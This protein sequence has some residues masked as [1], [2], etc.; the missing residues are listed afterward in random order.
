MLARYGPRIT[1]VVLLLTGTYLAWYWYPAATGGQASAGSAAV[2]TGFAATVSGWIQGH[3]TLIA[4]LASA[5]VVA[6]VTLAV[7]HRVRT[8]RDTD[9]SDGSSREAQA[10]CCSPEAS[11]A[12]TTP[13]L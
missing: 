12:P 1:A 6:V 11:P 13:D 2:L 10:D 9:P 7:R 3:T 5:A 4:V 8:R